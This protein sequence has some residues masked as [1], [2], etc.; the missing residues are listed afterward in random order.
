MQQVL[1]MFAV[2]RVFFIIYEVSKSVQLA[3]IE[4]RRIECKA[5]SLCFATR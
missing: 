3:N 1:A 4:L 5:A 2:K